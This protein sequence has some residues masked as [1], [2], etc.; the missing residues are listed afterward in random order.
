MAQG[1]RR[2]VIASGAWPPMRFVY[3]A[4]WRLS[5]CIAGL[6]FR[7]AAD[8][9]ALLLC[10]SA[11]GDWTPGLSD[12][13]LML[14][15]DDA[16]ESPLVPRLQG[17]WRRHAMLRRV[18]PHLHDFEII[19]STSLRSS[20]RR[21]FGPMSTKKRFLPL[22]SSFDPELN[23][24]I[25]R[26]HESAPAAE[27]RRNAFLRYVI[28]YLPAALRAFSSTDSLAA[29]QLSR[30]A[31][32][33]EALCGAPVAVEA[34]L[35][36][37]ARTAKVLAALDAASPRDERPRTEAVALRKPGAN[38][39][40]DAVAGRCAARLESGD[41]A[42]IACLAWPDSPGGT[43]RTLAFVLSTEGLAAE[44]VESKLVRVLSLSADPLL[45]DATA[46]ECVPQQWRMR[47]PHP[48]VFSRAAFVEWLRL[49]PLNA[50][51]LAGEG[52]HVWGEA[53]AGISVPAAGE[54]REFADVQLGVWQTRL[55]RWVCEDDSDARR[56]VAGL[57]AQARQL[58]RSLDPDADET[59]VAPEGES[60]D[61]LHE[62]AWDSLRRLR[63]CLDRR[64]PERDG[65]GANQ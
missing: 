64:E 45:R 12:A 34:G 38:A 3:R 24:V 58:L 7:D 53:E 15:V 23:A 59:D 17:H 50:L 26:G 36:V 42:R 27:H 11:D 54:L 44:E 9:R 35:S 4:A 10:E 41:A 5:L 56:D 19:S 60:M 48:L 22:F 29:S 43:R 55:H 61:A 37:A 30:I 20:G 39:F 57:L 65:A 8:A 47:Q 6:A 2:F 1:L 49:Y 31:G 40:L 46:M 28:F 62:A 21:V 14:V 51:Q 33:V 25:Q 32:K 18:F 16:G 13:D 63:S 52:V